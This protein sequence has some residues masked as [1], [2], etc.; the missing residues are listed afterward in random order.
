MPVTDPIADLLTRIRNAIMAGRKVVDCP[1]SRMKEQ[2]VDILVREHYLRAVGGAV[3]D[4]L[5]GG[6]AGVG[7]H[8]N[9]H[10]NFLAKRYIPKTDPVYYRQRGM[11]RIQSSPVVP[12]TT[13]ELP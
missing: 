7:I 9:L 11:P 8:P 12:P 3:E 4:I 1:R 2:I 10:E 5:D 6:R 13:G